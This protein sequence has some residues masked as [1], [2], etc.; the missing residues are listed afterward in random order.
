MRIQLGVVGVRITITFVDVNGTAIDI[1]SAT[2]RQILARMPRTRTLST[3]S[4]TF[5]TDG[6]DG[7][8][9]YDTTSGDFDETGDAR[10]QGRAAGTGF[11]WYT[12]TAE[13]PVDAN[14]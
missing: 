3:F 14:A 9:Y 7:A 2:T 11:D 4:A 6:T 8:I 5:L 1:S 12:E 13:L 10:I